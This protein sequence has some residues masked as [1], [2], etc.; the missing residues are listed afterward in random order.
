MESEQ[1]AEPGLKGTIAE[2]NTIREFLRWLEIEK[3]WTVLTG[4]GMP[5]EHPKA[6]G[7]IGLLAEYRKV[8]VIS[9]EV[10]HIIT[11][12]CG[13]YFGRDSYGD[14]IIVAR[15]V[16]WM[17]V[18]DLTLKSYLLA[19]VGEGENIAEIIEEYRD[20]ES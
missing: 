13:G 6:E 5:F 7:L 19:Q 9:Q 2:A 10:G 3:G 12:Y 20:K 4:T 18:Y 17:V 8:G 1:H 16:R 14:K 11:G 15:G